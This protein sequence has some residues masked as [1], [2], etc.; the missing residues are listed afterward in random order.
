MQPTENILEELKMDLW[1]GV[2]MNKR[3]AAR[4]YSAKPERIIYTICELA[5]KNDNRWISRDEIHSALEE[6]LWD[7][8]IPGKKWNPVDWFS[9]NYTRVEKNIYGAAKNTITRWVPVLLRRK[10]GKYEYRIRDEYFPYIK[11][12]IQE[13]RK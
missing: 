7:F 4:I 2:N 1:A 13:M 3:I 6:D 11:D 10:R 12:L 8:I 5:V 9:S